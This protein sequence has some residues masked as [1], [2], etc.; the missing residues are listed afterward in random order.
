MDNG[1]MACIISWILL[2]YG[3]LLRY[4]WMTSLRYIDPPTPMGKLLGESME[5]IMN[6]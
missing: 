1:C 6:D 3:F 4:S 2:S 5:H